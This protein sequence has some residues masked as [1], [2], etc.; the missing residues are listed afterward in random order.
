V[1]TGDPVMEDR[2]RMIGV[3]TIVGGVRDAPAAWRLGR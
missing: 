2:T 1:E 3:L